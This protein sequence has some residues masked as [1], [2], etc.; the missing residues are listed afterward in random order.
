MVQ[1]MEC[2]IKK[3][4]ERQ[5]I[6]PCANMAK[7]GVQAVSSY[8]AGYLMETAATVTRNALHQ[9]ALPPSRII[10]E[11]EMLCTKVWRLIILL[12]DDNRNACMYIVAS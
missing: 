12:H 7:S 10:E 8:I 2:L 3:S 4:P 5:A 1:R 6:T 11:K 9:S